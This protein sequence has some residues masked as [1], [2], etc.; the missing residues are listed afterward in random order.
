MK[1]VPGETGDSACLVGF[2]V[3]VLKGYVSGVAT[4]ISMAIRR[5]KKSRFS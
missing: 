2:D 5:K 1:K 3:V 4:L